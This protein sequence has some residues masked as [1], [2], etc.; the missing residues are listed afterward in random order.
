[1]GGQKVDKNTF[2]TNFQSRAEL[3]HMVEWGTV[4]TKDRMAKMIIEEGNGGSH[5]KQVLHRVWIQM[6]GLPSELREYLTIWTIGT[7]FG[8]TKDVDMKFTREYERDRRQV[9]VL[10]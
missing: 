8:V 6:M 3:N 9:L 5:F 2:R 1:M 10:D 4:Q 7:I